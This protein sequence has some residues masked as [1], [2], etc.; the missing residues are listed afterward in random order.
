MSFS[1]LMSP[2]GSTD[3]SVPYSTLHQ[4]RIQS[5]L[6]KENI[7]LTPGPTPGTRPSPANDNQVSTW[8]ALPTSSVRTAACGCAAVLLLLLRKWRVYMNAMLLKMHMPRNNKLIR[9]VRCR[10][11]LCSG[12]SRS[13]ETNFHALRGRG[14][15]GAVSAW[16]ALF[17]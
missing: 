9:F 13:Q 5:G 1:T 14:I 3:K 8:R 10:T 11:R 2:P 12:L 17:F 16:R 6:R 7:R 15:C 4:T